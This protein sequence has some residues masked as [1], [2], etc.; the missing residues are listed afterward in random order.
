[1]EILKEIQ[2]KTIII[3]ENSYKEAILE[4]MNNHHLFLPLKFYTKKEF[5]QEY[6]FSFDEKT[7]YY[8]MKKYHYKIDVIKMYLKNLYFINSDSTYQNPKLDFLVKLKQELNQEQ[9]L[10][11]NPMFQ[12]YLKDY[13]III[14]G[15]DYLENYEKEILSKLKAIFYEDKIKYKPKEVLKFATLKEEVSYITHSIADLINNN[16]SINKIK[17]MNVSEEYYNDLRL[18]FTLYN[19]PIKIPTSNNLLSNAIIR[20]FLNH[21]SDS[22]EYLT[23][24]NNDFSNK[25]ITILNKYPFVKEENYLKELLTYE[26]QKTPVDNFKEENYVKLIDINDYVSE[27]DYVFLLNF[28]AGIIPKTEKDEDYIT[29][30][31]KPLLK[32]DNTILKNK[33]IKEYTIKKIQKI[34]NLVITYKLKDTKKEYYP[35]I[36]VSELGLQEVSKKEDIL[37]SYS[38][39]IDKIKLA[40][41]EDEYYKYGTISDEY[42]IY[43]NNLNITY[44][45]Y[46]NKFKG[47]DLNDLKNYLNNELTLSYSSLNNYN[48][49]AFRFYIA[50]ILKLDKY[51]ETFEAFIG[52]LFHYLLSLNKDINIDEE[53]NTYLNKNAKVLTLKERV[54][55]RKIKEDIIF[56]LEEVKKQNASYG[57]NNTLCEKKIVIDKSRE[58]PIYFKGFVDKILYKEE[59]NQTLVAIIDYKTG[60]VSTKLNYLLYGLNLQLPIYL[61]LV[62]KSNLFTNPVFVGFYLQFILNNNILRDNKKSYQELKRENLKLDGYS[63]TSESIIS[64]LDSNYQ[65]SHLIKSLK[66]NSDGNFSAYAKVL[67]NEQMDHVTRLTEKNIDENITKIL[68]GEFTINPKKIGY[69]NDIGCEYC[70]FRDI[71]FKKENDY[72]ILEE[73]NSLNFLGGDENA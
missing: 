54:Y 36:L 24:L 41:L 38:L 15:Y 52:S 71:C 59:N 6:L 33:Q 14:Y 39:K 50:N 60:N 18:Y 8:L 2:Q 11:Y 30:Y 3:C 51:E 28:S 21:I 23:Q 5:F 44:N 10:Y 22:Q 65:N 58:I 9:L 37:N 1:M 25:I 17:L 46:D 43:K 16:V 49:C 62:K 7:I 45:T 63:N 47:I 57:L 19:I 73:I 13:Q 56:V 27:D 48:K 35:S 70:H 64:R 20:D 55:L 69:E 29:D 66:V 31:I 67:T 72:V 61:Y 53:I 26:F 68:N 12:E 34:K 40:K 42:F 4:E 32:M